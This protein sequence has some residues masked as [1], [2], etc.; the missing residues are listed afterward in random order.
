MEQAVIKR[1]DL[2]I[3]NF[4]CVKYYDSL[5]LDLESKVLMSP[6]HP[7]WDSYEIVGH[8][9]SSS[10]AV[11]ATLGLMTAEEAEAEFLTR[12]NELWLKRNPR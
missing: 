1:F 5:A 7:I 4:D 6:R 3:A 10:A 2:Q 8:E 11:Y 12:F 9:P